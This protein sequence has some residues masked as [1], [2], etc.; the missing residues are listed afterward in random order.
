MIYYSSSYEVDD[1]PILKTICEF[2]NK[3]RIV[4]KYQH[5]LLRHIQGTK[6]S[7]KNLDDSDM[8]IVGATYKSDKCLI[9]KGCYS[10]ILRALKLNKPVFLISERKRAV[11]RI[12]SEKRLAI[13]DKTTFGI[14]YAEIKLN[15][16]PS[17]WYDLDD[18]KHLSKIENMLRNSINNKKVIIDYIN[19]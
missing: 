2:I 8:V 13:I 14:G 1:K 17:Y 9:G 7:T 16:F 18:N 11:Y 10:E 12:Y 6:Y 15:Y 4:N 5:T 19:F 3:Y